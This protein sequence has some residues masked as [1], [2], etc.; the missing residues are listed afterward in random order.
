M[1]S[2]FVHE[3]KRKHKYTTRACT[4]L[5]QRITEPMDKVDRRYRSIT[6]MEEELGISKY[7]IKEFI[8]SREESA[9]I[10]SKRDGVL[11]LLKKPERDLAISARS[12]DLDNGAPPYQEFTSMYQLIKRFRVSYETVYE[13]KKM[14]P[15][16]V[17]CKK[18]INDEFKRKYYLTFHK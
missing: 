12:A 4:Y 14:Q 3:E 7:L 16:C 6:K 8:K 11:Y 15:L 18:A 10:R 9:Y 5:I 1:P 13:M 2:H 17:E